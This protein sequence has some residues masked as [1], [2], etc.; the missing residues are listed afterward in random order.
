MP[1]IE[2]DYSPPVL[3]RNG[4][5]ST[6]YSGLFRK[7][8]F[9]GYT[10]QRLELEDG[11]FL[12]LDW[13]YSEDGNNRLVILLHG[14][15]GDSQRAYMAG[16]ALHL[17]KSGFD[18]CA[19]NFRGC[20]GSPNR[21]FRS[22]H[23][24]ATDDLHAILTGII[25]K[26][27][28]SQVYL[29]GFS[30]GGNVALKYMGEGRAL[31]EELK[32]AVGIS[33]PCD[34]YSSLRSIMRPQNM[35]YAIRFKRSLLAKLKTKMGSFAGQVSVEEFRKVKTLQDFDDLYTS[36]AHGF[37]DAMDYY[38]RCSCGPFLEQIP[39]PVLLINARNDSFLGPECYPE[40]IASRN[41]RIN[42]EI[43]K[44]GGHVGFYGPQNFYYS[45]KRA[46]KFMMEAS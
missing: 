5:I 8:D 39:R 23:S 41:N 2:S 43:P 27:Q 33:V 15:E 46:I 17:N 42:L 22:Y 44:Y 36:R 25:E 10:R 37:K 20:S 28:Y 29:K 6:I 40:E 26:D 32:G 9:D 12:D 21:L 45:E 7:V 30:L 14:L 11:D 18:V 38:R 1:Q 4:H 13:S 3:F 16:S 24:G 35:A 34:L 31:P 19:V